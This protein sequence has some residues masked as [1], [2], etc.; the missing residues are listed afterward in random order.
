MTRQAWQVAEGAVKEAVDQAIDAVLEGWL[1]V[2]S[3]KLLDWQD[4]DHIL[5]AYEIILSADTDS[6]VR[7]ALDAWLVA[8]KASF[9]G[10]NAQAREAIESKEWLYMN[11]ATGSVDTEEGWSPE[12]VTGLVKVDFDWHQLHWK[13]AQI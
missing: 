7:E 6:D 8:A 13:E 3:S 9:S 12:P 5:D 11:P 1:D 10:M 4:A 2:C